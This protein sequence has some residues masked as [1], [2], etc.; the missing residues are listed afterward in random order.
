MASEI[1]QQAAGPDGAPQA[2]TERRAD[3]SN[4]EAVIQVRGLVNRFGE[5][6]VHEGLDLDVRRGEIFG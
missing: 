2:T 5:Q 4:H 6:T 3:S 1:G